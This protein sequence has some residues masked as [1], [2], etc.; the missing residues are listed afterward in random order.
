[1]WLQH[2]KSLLLCNVTKLAF[3]HYQWWKAE[4]THQAMFSLHEGRKAGSDPLY[5]CGGW[6]RTPGHGIAQHTDAWISLQRLYLQGQR[7]NV[8][9]R[10]PRH[11]TTTCPTPPAVDVKQPPQE[12]GKEVEESQMKIWLCQ[13]GPETLLKHNDLSLPSLVIFICCAWCV[14]SFS[15]GSVT[16]WRWQAPSVLNHAVQREV[17]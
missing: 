6:H 14:A 1:M 4:V 16:N 7:T 12:N 9:P 2:Y 17:G 8:G 5:P 10:C 11:G 13:W 15:L 3:L